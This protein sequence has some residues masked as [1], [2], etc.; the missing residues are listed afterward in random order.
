MSP[1]LLF[2]VVGHNRHILDKFRSTGSYLLNFGTIDPIEREIVI[3]RTCARC[4]AE[5]EWGVHVVLYG[6]RVGLSEEQIGATVLGTADSPVWTE[7]H[8]ILIKLV[9]ELHDTAAVSDALWA[10][11]QAG[12]TAAQLVELLAIVGQY[13][14]VS[15]FTNVL[16]LPLETYAEHFPAGVRP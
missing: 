8:G 16:R 7:R 3:D 12:W 10:E 6:R 5:Y 4:G 14:M 1:L 13:H 11:L 15:Y 9:D 2:R